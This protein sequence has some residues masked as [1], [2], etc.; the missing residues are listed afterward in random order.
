MTWLAP[1]ALAAAA[2]AAIGVALLHLLARDRPPRYTLPT[3]RFV[4]AGSARATRRARTPRDLLLLALRVLAIVLAGAAFAGPL[5]TP[6]R[7][8]VA[9]VV[10]LD[11]STRGATRVAATDSARARLGETG[12][13]VVFDSGAYAVPQGAERAVLDSLARVAG[14]S[15][16]GTPVRGSLS[17]GLVAA[18]R[19]A[20]DA[21][22]QADSVVLAIVSRLTGVEDA[23]TVRI[24][25][26]WPGR[27]EVVAGD[28][29]PASGVGSGESGRPLP[30]GRIAAA[31]GPAIVVRGPAT[32]PVVAAARLI[33]AAH[34]PGS[35]VA[36]TR[37]V[38]DVPT[39]ADSVFARGGGTLLVWP[40]GVSAPSASGDT[41]GGFVVEEIPVLFATNRNAAPPAGEVMA[42]WV[43]GV[44]AV[45]QAAHGSGCILSLI[46]I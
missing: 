39:A 28:A 43:D 15:V 33:G 2:A 27:I 23:A 8:S 35:S 13:L 10:L 26:L 14:D 21:A 1:W 46:H 41:I 22:Q 18:L 17:A 29:A 19:T 4:A 31:P 20:A 44:P 37:I 16:G 40:A 9:T 11:A 25:E 45:T 38:R 42:R 34:G 30:S 32:D 24:R 12:R 3:T 7:G 5:L 36:G 6:E